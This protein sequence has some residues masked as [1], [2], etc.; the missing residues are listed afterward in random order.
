MSKEAIRGIIHKREDVVID[1]KTLHK[2]SIGLIIITDKDIPLDEMDN[3]IL[4]INESVLGNNTII[5]TISTW[6]FYKP[7][8]ILG[9]LGDGLSLISKFDIDQFKKIKKKSK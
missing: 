6:D 8:C 5:D 4:Q 1:G 2:Y 7:P 9:T 3:C